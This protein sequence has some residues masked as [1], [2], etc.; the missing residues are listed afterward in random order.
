MSEIGYYRYKLTP[1]AVG[2]TTVQLYINGALASTATIVVKEFCTGFKV[3]K[4]L[5]RSGRYRFFP[6][7]DRWQQRD[8]PNEL[9]TVNKFVT[10]IYSDQGESQSIGYRNARTISLAAGGVSSAELSILSDIFTSP[11]VYLYVGSGTTDTTEDWVLVKV[12]GDGVG[13]WRNAKFG[14][15]NIDIQLPEHYS[16]NQN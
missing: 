4:Y 3:I 13:R 10:S 16:I 12:T 7:N 8:R 2:T 9:G 5:D 1:S 6:F 11:R 14:K 15:V